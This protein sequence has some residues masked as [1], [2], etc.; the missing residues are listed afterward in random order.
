MKGDV[1]EAI[2]VVEYLV[3]QGSVVVCRVLDDS[4][5]VVELGLAVQGSDFVS[6]IDVG[7]GVGV[8]SV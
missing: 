6:W 4:W 5:V 7:L 1:D 2:P 3:A 8:L